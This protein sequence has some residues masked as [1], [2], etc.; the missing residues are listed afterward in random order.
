MIRFDKQVAVVTGSGRGLGAAY[1]TLLAARG[2]AVI[3][4]DAGVSPEGS[5]VDPTVADA[6]VQTITAA[7]GTAVANYEQLDTMAGCQRVIA[8]ALS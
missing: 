7:R 1:A 3:V 8:A 5:G 2:A 6:V 4:H